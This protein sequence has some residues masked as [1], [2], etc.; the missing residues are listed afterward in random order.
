MTQAPEPL[1]ETMPAGEFKAKCLAIMDRVADT[2]GQLII[3]KYGQPVAALVPCPPPATDVPELW[4]SCKGEI[5]VIG[6]LNEPTDHELDWL[7]DWEA[8]WA[9]FLSEAPDAAGI[10]RGSRLATADREILSWTGD[11]ERIDVR[12]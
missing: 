8:E 10:N 12:T 4:G 9:E 11:L 6:D 5:T 2:G 1:P 7:S 3:T